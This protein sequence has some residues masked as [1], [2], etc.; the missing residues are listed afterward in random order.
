M[1]PF[2]VQ[3][4]QVPVSGLLRHTQ[5][6]LQGRLNV[7]SGRSVGDLHVE[8]LAAETSGLTRPLILERGS[9]VLGERVEMGIDCAQ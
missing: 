3:A 9:I 5:Y 7:D 1:R 4:P 8:T 2:G 6:D